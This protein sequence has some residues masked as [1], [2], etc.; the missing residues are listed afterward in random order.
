ME[1]YLGVPSDGSA[2]A[3]TLQSASARPLFTPVDC[4][5]TND[6]PGNANPFE[7]L[8]AGR[9]SKRRRL[10]RKTGLESVPMASAFG[11]CADPPRCVSIRAR[12][13]QW[14]SFPGSTHTCFFAC[15][16]T[17]VRELWPDNG[18]KVASGNKSRCARNT[19]HL[20]RQDGQGTSVRDS[21][22]VAITT[23]IPPAPFPSTRKPTTHRF[24]RIE[25]TSCGARGARTRRAHYPLFGPR[26]PIGNGWDGESGGSR[27]D[28]Y[29]PRCDGALH[30]KT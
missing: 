25:T 11:D 21:M 19:T 22:E 5:S 9:P 29:P 30:L 28:T 16:R 6:R 26:E 18:T 10:V 20:D 1:K 13:G 15:A 12:E 23:P 24:A 14:W 2:T 4:V 8:P 17:R 27:T 3:K 7:N